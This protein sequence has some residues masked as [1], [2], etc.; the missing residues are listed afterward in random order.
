[1]FSPLKKLSRSLLP[2]R[3]VVDLNFSDFFNNELPNMNSCDIDYLV[4]SRLNDLVDQIQFLYA[5]GDF[6]T[7]ALLQQEGCELASFADSG[8]P[9]L[10]INDLSEV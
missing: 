1:M 4:Q 2:F 8:S 5:Q 6:E 7:A 10:F 9:F 3:P